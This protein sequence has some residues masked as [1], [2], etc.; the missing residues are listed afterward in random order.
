[1]YYEEVDDYFTLFIIDDYGELCTGEFKVSIAT[2]EILQLVDVKPQPAVFID[3]DNK[4][5]I[6]CERKA[7][8]DIEELA[9]PELRLA[10]LRI[11]PETYSQS[12]INYFYGMQL[13]EIATG[14]ELPI[15]NLPDSLKMAYLSFS[16]DNK[17]IAFTNTYRKNI[18]LWV[19]DIQTQ[20]ARMI[21]HQRMN[22]CL[23]APYHWAPD[24]ESLLVN[25]VPENWP[26]LPIDKPL[27]EG[28]IVQETKGEKS[29]VR[30]YQD[31]LKNP[32]DENLFEHYATSAILKIGL[33]G[34]RQHFYPQQ[35]IK[36]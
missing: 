19:V 21:Y 18:S 10:G 15:E 1:M 25:V 26:S 32:Y 4:Y 14:K 11:N 7:F 29:A 27:P 3:Y 33:D 2:D 24:S 23:G 22:A 31:L 36:A 30:T 5:M 13:I 35:Y 34:S 20:Q 28:P 16:P 17:K 8:K 9:Q 12:R 6:L